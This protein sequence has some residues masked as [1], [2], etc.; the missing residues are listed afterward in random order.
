MMLCSATPSEM[1]SGNKVTIEGLTKG[2]PYEFRI[3]A[4]NGVGIGEYA[5]TKEPCT[6]PSSFSYLP[7]CIL[8]KDR[9]EIRMVWLSDG[10][11]IEY[12]FICFMRHLSR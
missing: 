5:Q 3:A 1:V 2:K 12:M 7:L 6:P 8:V 11:N 10:E 4:V 9:L